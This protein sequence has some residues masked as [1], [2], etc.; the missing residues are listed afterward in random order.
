M[1]GGSDGSGGAGAGAADVHCRVLLFI[2]PLS[3][4]PTH[5]LAR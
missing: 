2:H 1:D 4:S 3:H 5:F